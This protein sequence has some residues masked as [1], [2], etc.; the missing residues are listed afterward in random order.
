MRVLQSH[1]SAYPYVVSGFDSNPR[2]ACVTEQSLTSW[3]RSGGLREPS[4]LLIV[5][6]PQFRPAPEEAAFDVLLDGMPAGQHLLYICSGL[7]LRQPHVPDLHRPVSRS[8]RV[9]WFRAHAAD[10]SWRPQPCL[11]LAVSSYPLILN[12][13]SEHL[14]SATLLIRKSTVP[15]HCP[16]QTIEGRGSCQPDPEELQFQRCPSI[17][18]AWCGGQ[19]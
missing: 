18:G 3:C 14:T 16:L 4:G 12:H 10:S 1:S 17:L 19:K 8:F 7:T 13:G 9:P 2:H 15:C 6:W 5:S 11:C